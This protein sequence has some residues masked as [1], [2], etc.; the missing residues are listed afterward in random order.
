ML[1]RK[2]AILLVEPENPDNIGAAARSMKNMA[3]CDLRLVGPPADWEIKAR[4]L[5][6]SALDILENA[7][8]FDSVKAAI[9]DAVLV[10]GTTRRIR[11]FNP[12]RIQF[13]EAVQKLKVMSRRKQ[14]V[15]MFGKESK[16]LDNDSLDHCDLITSIPVSAD[17][18][19]MNLAQAVMV[20]T[21]ALHYALGDSTPAAD[22]GVAGEFVQKKEMFEVLEVLRGALSILGYQEEPDVLDRIIHTFHGLMKRGGLLKREEQMLKGIS[23]RIR[24]RAK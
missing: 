8:V 24:E 22:R 7:R 9:Q 5:A 2:V 17:Y 4:K 14:V 23:R 21:F 20:M 1:K 12:N 18:P 19:S 3:L 10:V 16:G 13:T 11:R 6:V 15:I